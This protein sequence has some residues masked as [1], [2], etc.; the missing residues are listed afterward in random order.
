MCSLR[1]NDLFGAQAP[2]RIT[3]QTRSNSDPNLRQRLFQSTPDELE[4]PNAG[5][6]PDNVNKSNL[7]E[8]HRCGS[9]NLSTYSNHINEFLENR[10]TLSL[11]PEKAEGMIQYLASLEVPA[12]LQEEDQDL[13]INVPSCSESGSPFSSPLLTPPDEENIHHLLRA[14]QE[15]ERE[16]LEGKGEANGE[17]E[18]GLEPMEDDNQLTSTDKDVTK[19][20]TYSTHNDLSSED[21][22]PYAL[23]D[24]SSSPSSPIPHSRVSR[25]ASLPLPLCPSS[26]STS[27]KLYSRN[28]PVSPK[29]S[30]SIRSPSSSRTHDSQDHMDELAE[31]EDSIDGQDLPSAG[32]E[33]EEGEQQVKTTLIDS[34]TARIKQIEEM[35]TTKNQRAS[36]PGNQN[37]MSIGSLSHASSDESVN[38]SPPR[39]EDPV[40]PPTI[41]TS[42]QLSVIENGIKTSTLSPSPELLTILSTN[43]SNNTS[44]PSSPTFNFQ[45]NSI[46]VSSTVGSDSPNTRYKKATTQSAILLEQRKAEKQRQTKVL[47]EAEQLP[48]E[49][50]Q[51]SFDHLQ[52]PSLEISNHDLS[53]SADDLRFHQSGKGVR[54]LL[55][56][57]DDQRK[58]GSLKRSHSLRS[59]KQI[60]HSFSTHKRGASSDNIL[61]L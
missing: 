38:L 20:S 50:T 26:A 27:E 22:Q 30:S 13:G 18:K 3:Y 29:K 15:S 61:D 33:S 44:N 25:A 6:I 23:L 19:I 4:P 45:T 54:Q 1:Y 21:R 40:D 8:W 28:Y 52:M 16:R 10:A 24:V 2:S 34:V 57:F 42:N 37:R 9:V 49:C 43:S 55:D 11:P 59:N 60:D 17:D 32:D 39:D 31:V 51:K 56:I 53:A 41:N 35:N 12:L 7:E 36:S 46:N 48:N 47:Q 58:G 14:F 5:Y